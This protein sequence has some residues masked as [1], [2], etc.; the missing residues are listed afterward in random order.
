MLGSIVV[1][2]HKC[3]HSDPL[4]YFA[5]PAG[6]KSPAAE[7]W[8]AEVATICPEEVLPRRAVTGPIDFSWHQMYE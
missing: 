7:H 4:L 5:H 8:R 6:Q 2:G 3:H 1:S